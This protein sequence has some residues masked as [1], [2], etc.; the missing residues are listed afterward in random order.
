MPLHSLRCAHPC[1]TQER[2]SGGLAKQRWDSSG[3]APNPRGA[4]T[5][6]PRH[7]GACRRPSF[8]SWLPSRSGAWPP[9]WP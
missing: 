8:G 6:C 5:T 1:A 9:P 3:R 4:T 2:A 7:T